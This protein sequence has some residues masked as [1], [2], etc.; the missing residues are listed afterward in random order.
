ME[1]QWRLSDINVISFI[2]H[3][4]NL[5]KCYYHTENPPSTYLRI[6]TGPKVTLGHILVITIILS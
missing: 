6:A 1:K 2:L 4:G 3:V 5:D